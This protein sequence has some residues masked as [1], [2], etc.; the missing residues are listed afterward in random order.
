[1]SFTVEDSAKELIRDA[2]TGAVR[3]A[4]GTGNE[5]S[6]QRSFTWESGGKH[7]WLG[8][9]KAERAAGKSGVP[10]SSAEAE[11]AVKKYGTAATAGMPAVG[12]I[13]GFKVLKTLIANPK[14]FEAEIAKARSDASAFIHRDLTAATQA[15]ARTIQRTATREAMG[16]SLVANFALPHQSAFT[17]A[18]KVALGTEGN[19][20]Q[21]LEAA[22]K[23]F[24]TANEG[25]GAAKLNFADM[26]D[27][28]KLRAMI[29]AEKPGDF[30]AM[31]GNALHGNNAHGY[32]LRGSGDG[33]DPIYNRQP[34]F[35][36]EALN[37][38]INQYNQMMSPASGPIWDTVTAAMRPFV[39]VWQL[40]NRVMPSY[41]IR[42]QLQDLL[43][44]GQKGILS[45]R[46]PEFL[47]SLPGLLTGRVQPEEWSA[48]VNGTKV[49]GNWVLD[50]FYNRT[51]MLGKGHYQQLMAEP[52]GTASKADTVGHF[53]ETAP[54]ART[55]MAL[56]DY[57]GAL[58]ATREDVNRG[59]ALL[60]LLDKGDVPEIAAMK[61]ERAL[62]DYSRVSP[63][64]QF[65]RQTG[66]APFVAW[67]AKNIPAQ[68]AWAAENPGLALAAARG[69]SSIAGGVP[70]QLVSQQLKEKF[71]INTGYGKDPQT[72]KPTFGVV[73]MDGLLPFADLTELAKAPLDVVRR[74]LGPLARLLSE[75][76]DR[77]FN[78]EK[79]TESFAA[80]IGRKPVTA[81]E[82]LMA[83][84]QPSNPKDPTSLRNPSVPAV[85]GQLISPVKYNEVDVEQAARKSELQLKSAVAS[86][87]KA[88]KDV[89][90]EYSVAQ[91]V[92]PIMADKLPGIQQRIIQA[93]YA[94]TQAIAQ[95]QTVT[96]QNQRV[97][98]LAR[99][100]GMAK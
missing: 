62:Y 73:T 76:A 77:H 28:D 42:N 37:T 59:A 53:L 56:K 99:R 12:D 96:A 22:E 10:M 40:G 80:S 58:S 23:A 2:Q 30:N 48:V 29:D 33:V 91:T 44:M 7:D 100:M 3:R 19:V 93:Q 71:N 8:P 26:L 39:R 79:A 90:I 21:K 36:P 82:H 72:G 86:A 61:V 15:Q 31:V 52:I 32:V 97:L 66:L 65:L 81:I 84:G 85:L 68:A 41:H 98:E 34:Y 5:A 78:P 88:L 4:A 47:G 63:A 95:M 69:M 24:H 43:L 16:N 83:A 1:M 18:C 87:A 14:D 20:A 92:G 25:T 35:V 89:Q 55:V 38:A 70:E 60:S 46:T 45:E 94:R 13:S 9:D 27:G 64:A 50:Q 57:A 17:A 6:K 51:G 67:S 11:E 54:G 74:N 75:V 49:D